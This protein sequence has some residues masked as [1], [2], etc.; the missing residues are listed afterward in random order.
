M[1]KN[2]NVP[3]GEDLDILTAILQKELDKEWA[4]FR[5]HDLYQDFERLHYWLESKDFYQL[6]DEGVEIPST[7]LNP[8]HFYA[9]QTICQST[10]QLA[11][12]Y[13]V[14]FDCALP[15]RLNALLSKESKVGGHEVRVFDFNAYVKGQFLTKY[16]LSFFHD[17]GQFYFLEPPKLRT[18]AS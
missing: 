5:D 1:A 6:R 15:G 12:E 2:L 7:I 18:L 10:V 3:L 11:G 8:S 9:A 17:H 16:S 4:C 14:Y 13:G